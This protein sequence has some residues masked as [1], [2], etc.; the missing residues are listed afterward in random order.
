M[1]GE[2]CHRLRLL[3][4]FLTATAGTKRTPASFR[5]TSRMPKTKARCGSVKAVLRKLF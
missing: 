2:H 3:R 1:Y 5:I 4:A